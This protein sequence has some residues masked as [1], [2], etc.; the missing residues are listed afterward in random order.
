MFKKPVLCKGC[1]RL[2]SVSAFGTHKKTAPNGKQY[3]FRRYLCKECTSAEAAEKRSKQYDD[4]PVR[5]CVVCNSVLPAKNTKK[6]YCS[7][8]CN[9]KAYYKKNSKK[10]ISLL[11]AKRDETRAPKIQTS[12]VVCGNSFETI[13]PRSKYCSPKCSVAGSYRIKT[14]TEAGRQK[15]L[16]QHRKY[17]KTP[18]GKMIA[19]R[20]RH[21]RRSVHTD[22]TLADWRNALSYFDNKCAYCGDPLTT[23][24][25][26]HFVPVKLGGTTT[27]DNIVPSCRNCNTKKYTKHPLDWLVMQAHGLVAYVRVVQFLNSRG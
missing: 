9:A 17:S 1:N 6:I 8:L 12:C 16:E 25:M 11:R 2:L 20:A 27:K 24:D 19:R 26:E 4:R 14:S 5:H 21:K 23:A 3:D 13:N 22:I 10:I 18:N 15:E 7:D